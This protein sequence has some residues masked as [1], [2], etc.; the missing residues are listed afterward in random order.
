M[1]SGNS[2]SHG[3]AFLH[4]A[5]SR[6]LTTPSFASAVQFNSFT[7]V[8]PPEYSQPLAGSSANLHLSV[9][10]WDLR[11]SKEQ[12]SQFLNP[13]Y[14]PEHCPDSWLPRQQ[15]KCLPFNFPHFLRF[16]LLDDVERQDIG[17]PQRKQPCLLKLS[18]LSSARPLSSFL[19]ASPL[20]L[21]P[22][23]T[24]FSKDEPNNPETLS[25]V[26]PRVGGSWIPSHFRKQ[27]FSQMPADF[28]FF[29]RKASWF[30]DP[31][32]LCGCSLEGP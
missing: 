19:F 27:S 7:Q 23:I 2:D 11:Y 9:W 10:D 15:V 26:G 29:F 17:V 1:G 28:T 5:S 31:S 30:L 16:T 6:A 25:L 8:H 21:C 13:G 22:Y 20:V 24:S 18:Y 4:E 12:I 3:S 32:V 14:N